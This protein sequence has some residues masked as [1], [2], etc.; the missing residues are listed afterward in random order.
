MADNFELK[1]RLDD[2][3]LSRQL[4]ALTKSIDKLN[5]KTKETQKA[6]DSL[7]KSQK[8]LIDSEEQLIQKNTKLN[9]LLTNLT[10]SRQNETKALREKIIE[11]NKER[12]AE[13]KAAIALKK[14]NKE[15][16]ALA[17][18]QE[19]ARKTSA[20]L[21][22]QQEKER[23]ATIKGADAKRANAIE[24]KR[25]TQARRET[26]AL[27]KQSILQRHNLST[28]IKKTAKEQRQLHFGMIDITNQGR[29]LNN[30]FAVLRSRL[31]LASFGF[32]LI[33]GSVGRNIQLFAK[34]EESVARLGLQFGSVGAK[35]LSSFASELQKVTRFGDENINSV[36]SQFGAY[37]ANIEQTKLLTKATLDLAEGQNMDLQSASL[38]VSK[39]F[40]SSTN[41]LQR[42][43]IELDSSMSKQDKINAIITQSEAKYGGLAELLGQLSGS[44]LTQA[45]MAFGDLRESLGETLAE[46]FNP[47]INGITKV[48]EKLQGAPIRIFT[49]LI[50]GLTTSFLTLQTIGFGSKYLSALQTAMDTTRRFRAQQLALN[51]ATVTLTKSFRAFGKALLGTTGGLG[52]FLAIGSV[53]FTVISELFGAF[54]KTKEETKKADENLDKYA[55]TIKNLKVDNATEELDKLFEKLKEGNDLLRVSIASIE[56]ED[57][58]KEISKGFTQIPLSVFQKDATQLV[59]D[60]VQVQDKINKINDEIKEDRKR[61]NNEIKVLRNKQR[62]ADTKEERD[63]AAKRLKEA[64]GEAGALIEPLRQLQKQRD[65]IM[66][67]MNNQSNQIVQGFTVNNELLKEN[68]ISL[69]G[70][71]EDFFNKY[72]EG[73]GILEAI[74]NGTI[75]STKDL[76]DVI[77]E[78]I[79]ANGTLV[80]MDDTKQQKLI[81][82]IALKN[83]LSD[84]EKKLLDDLKRNKKFRDLDFDVQLRQVAQ[85][86]NAIAAGIG[87]NSANQ[88]EAA[89]LQQFAAT[90]D[91]I[92]GA[93]KALPNL[94]LSAAILAKGMAN[95]AKIE[96]QLQNMNQFKNVQT[97]EQGGLVGGNRH[98]QGGTII[99]AERGEFVMSRNAVQSIG[100]ETLNQ[101]NQGGSSG[102]VVVNV[103]GNVMTQDFVEGELAESIKEAVRRGSDFGLS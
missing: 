79:K 100:L 32:S 101:L 46:G 78:N 11:N 91:A 54:K 25:E 10:V 50:V 56:F 89:R 29:L 13:E 82:E 8:Q 53:A 23:I 15:L 102:N 39:A 86:T 1:F 62:L 87:V 7:K 48:N 81:K 9:G 6:S 40:G 34:Q 55:G 45:S 14:K 26:L 38:L 70:V 88:V 98:S 74:Q 66:A 36:M 99:E 93:N 18:K 42:Y 58:F 51:G 57:F 84:V 22:R 85:L 83:E 76:T 21:E 17:Q 37:G 103:T 90:I 75:K 44:A 63:A 47:I 94:V 20:D 24:L 64:K 96:A 5:L 16:I 60:Y 71:S 43:G 69:T 4:E 31:L 77:N 61:L 95:V 67:Q 73:S 59:A 65:Q 30:S 2:G 92:A 41:S 68:F 80:D 35:E 28:A 12:I 19:D 27:L 3:G 52:A 72:V 97:F 33:A 49:E